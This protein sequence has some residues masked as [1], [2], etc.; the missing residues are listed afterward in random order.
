MNLII[1]LCLLCPFAGAALSCSNRA[2]KILQL[3]KTNNPVI[4]LILT[5]LQLHC[6]HFKEGCL[7]AALLTTKSVNFI[8]IIIP[9]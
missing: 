1:R 9:N 7:Y 5:S 4:K 6:Q 8:S 3:L 2:E